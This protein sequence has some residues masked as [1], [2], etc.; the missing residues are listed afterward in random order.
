MPRALTEHDATVVKR[1][2]FGLLERY[3]TFDRRDLDEMNSKMPTPSGSTHQIM[4]A[5]NRVRIDGKPVVQTR[6]TTRK[7]KTFYELDYPLAESDFQGGP[8]TVCLALLVRMHQLIGTPAPDEERGDATEEG[9]DKATIDRLATSI[10]V[11]EPS[12]PVH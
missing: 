9:V 11:L 1:T 6:R 5:I 8:G 4:D 12:E 2:L 10:E 3:S 7:G